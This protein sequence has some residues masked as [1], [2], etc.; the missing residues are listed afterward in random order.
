MLGRPFAA[1]RD[2]LLRWWRTPTIRRNVLLGILGTVV[3][4]FA[5][6]WGAWARACAGNRCPSIEGLDAY[7]PDQSSKVYAADGRLIT[8]LGMERRTVIR[9]DEMSPALVEAFLTTED[10]RFYRH[11]GI[12][13]IRFFG[14]VKAN[15]IAGGVAEGFST[16]TMQ[17]A[18][19]LF[20]EDINRQ[21]RSP[22]RKL[23]E[24]R[25]ARQIEARYS[26]DQILELYLNQIDLGNR[27]FGVEAASQRYFGKSARDLNVAEAATLAAMPKAPS[28]Y[29]P[30]RHPARAVQRRNLIIGLLAD[31]GSISREEAAR[32]RAY[33][34]LLSSRDDYSGVAEYFVEFI[35]QQLDARFGPRLYTDGLRI[36][37]TL[38]LDI[39]QAAERALEAQLSSIETGTY[40]PYKHLTF[41]EYLERKAESEDE[42]E[43]TTTP[44]LQGLAVTLEART[45]RILAMVGGRDFDDSKF[46]RATQALRQPGSTFKPIVYTAAVR[47]GIPLTTIMV[48]EPITVQMPGS[49]PP[50]EPQNY[51]NQ[52]RG[53]M[54]LREAL[55]KSVNIIAIKLGMEIGEEAVVAEATRFGLV[56]SPIPAVPSIHLGSAVVK[57]LELIAAY[58]AFANNGE[59]ATPNGILRVEDR[60]GNILWQPRPRLDPV[61]DPQLA[62]IM[63]GA[64]Q[65]VVRRGTGTAAVVGL[66]FPVGGKTGTTN[67]GND[68]WFVGFTSDLVTGIWLGLDVPTRIK[69]NAQ[70]GILVAPAWRQMMTEVYERRSSPGGWAQPPGLVSVEIDK[71][72]GFRASP[73]CPS[74]VRVMDWFIPGTEPN[75]ACPI[76]LPG[77]AAPTED[78]PVDTAAAS[79]TPSAPTPAS[80]EH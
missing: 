13:W 68:V 72:T 24:A 3:F 58:T 29:N 1:L 56:A 62:W 37:T 9:L 63:N 52:F 51:D 35:R 10:K 15:I 46:N 18:G 76:H 54:P 47:A 17:L 39:Q 22:G 65:D 25:V 57:P 23:R 48:D 45:G 42:S 8:D 21:D 26:K 33:P 80:P 41:A 78:V 31:N 59:R 79:P 12:D 50:W 14:A 64:L 67:D 30:R 74:D 7:D 16:I 6:L 2:T 55:Y 36:Y 49:Q 75:E 11:H 61:M 19:N 60:Q 69:P 34:L 73:Y 4:A 40:G 70:G 66:G 44:Y 71:T 38:D 27:A 43:H 53:P 32:W 77:G 20:P 28:R 5:L